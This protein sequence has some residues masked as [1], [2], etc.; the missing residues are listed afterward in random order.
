[1]LDAVLGRLHGLHPQTID[2]SLERVERLLADLGSPQD[3]LPPVI[4]VA[5]TNGKGS[6]VA[7]L[8]AI[9]EAAGLRVHAYTSPHLVRFAERMRVAGALMEDSAL[10]ELL[11]DV[12]AVNAGRP[13]TFFEITTAAAF[14]AFSRVPADVTLL[15]TGLGGRLDATN[16]VERPALTV[17]TPISMD[18]EQFLGGNLAFIAAE[19]AA[20][21]KPGGDCV[22]ADQAPEADGA[23]EARVRQC[24]ATLYREGRDFS[25]RPHSGGMLYQGRHR[26]WAL[27]MPAL[28]GAHQMRNAGLALACIDRLRDRLPVPEGA[29]ARGLETV[30]WPARLQH[31]SHGP[32]VATLPPGWELWLD[33][34]H[35]PDAARV[36][37]VQAQSWREKPLDLVVGMLADKDVGGFLR[38][39][40]PF[41]RRLRAVTIPDEARSLSAAETA[42]AATAAG[43]ADAAPAG[44]AMEAVRAIAGRQPPGRILICGSLYLAGH[45]L[46]DH[47]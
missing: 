21:I 11:A 2:L 41:I 30:R 15:E 5:G 17:L 36:L 14:L 24:G 10:A 12:E 25:V 33:G 35:N 16:T 4:H 32:L 3:R 47:G 46:R 42:E 28:A 13:I 23:I 38:P 22:S 27:P 8:R 43:I 39:L 31:L 29:L 34:G 45:I 20:I 44:D 37:A 6:T 7:Y 40:A 18:H 26:S 19:K 9:F 1:M